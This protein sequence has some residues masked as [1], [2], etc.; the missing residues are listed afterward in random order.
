MH[1]AIEY[2]LSKP[3]LITLLPSIALGLTNIKVFV[4]ISTFMAIDLSLALQCFTKLAKMEQD[5]QDSW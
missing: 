2:Q 5:K 1:Q 3:L 4:V